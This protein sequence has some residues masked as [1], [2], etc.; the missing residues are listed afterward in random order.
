M[1]GKPNPTPTHRQHFR[2]TSDKGEC[3][4]IAVTLVG[5]VA[6]LLFIGEPKN[7]NSGW[8][9]FAALLALAILGLGV[10]RLAIY[11]PLIRIFCD[12]CGKYVPSNQP[13]VCSRCDYQNHLKSFLDCC[14]ECKQAP[15]AYR[16]PHCGGLIFLDADQIETHPARKFTTDEPRN[17]EAEE[18]AQWDRDQR[19]IRQEIEFNQLLTERAKWVQRRKEAEEKADPPP[20]GPKPSPLEAHLRTMEE[21]IRLV[22][23]E[24]DLVDRELKEYEEKCRREGVAD[25]EIK[26]RLVR[27]KAAA[28]R[29]RDSADDGNG[30]PLRSR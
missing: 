26:V 21:A 28:L 9:V 22:A 10:R 6:M 1:D 14:E 25:T 13:W 7:Q 23:A 16:C 29:A 11:T 18:V 15:K 4:I 30:I 27:L 20:P 24:Q 12:H 19:R 3:G 8:N 5:A 17:T 2:T